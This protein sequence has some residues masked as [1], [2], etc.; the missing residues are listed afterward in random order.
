M[1]IQHDFLWN[2]YIPSPISEHTVWKIIIF[3]FSKKKWIK[4]CF[5]EQK[6]GNR[7]DY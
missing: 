4:I 3:S 5:N 1:E 7:L 6:G 2:F